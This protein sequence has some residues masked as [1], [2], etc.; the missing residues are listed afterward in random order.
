MPYRSS[1]QPAVYWISPASQ[2]DAETS[3]HRFPPSN[4]K[5]YFTLFSKF[6]S[7]FAH[8][9]CSLSVSRQYLAL[10]EIY[11]PFSV[12]IPGNATRRTHIVRGALHVM[13]GV[14]TLYDTLFQRIYTWGSCRPCVYRLQLDNPPGLTIFSL[15]SSLFTRRY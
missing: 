14:L 6:F 15:S 3:L 12:A 8:A 1:L 2:R 10:D 5:Y 7:S 13:N 4:F 11:H 9:T